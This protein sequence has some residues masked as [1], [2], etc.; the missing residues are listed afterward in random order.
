MKKI[1]FVALLA[2]C[3]N[4]IRTEQPDAGRGAYRNAVDRGLRQQT[5]QRRGHQLPAPGLARSAD[6]RSAGLPRVVLLVAVATAAAAG[7]DAR[8]LRDTTGSIHV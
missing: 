1:L 8:S 2:G 6:L 5:L 7:R 4:D 3:S